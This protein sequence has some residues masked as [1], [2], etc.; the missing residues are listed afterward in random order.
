MLQRRQSLYLFLV[1]ILSIV[2]F[3]GPLASVSSGDAVYFLKHSGVTDLSGERLEMSTWPL[4]VM[5]SISTLLS[6]LAIFSYLK[7]P[8]QMRMTL[9]LMF[10]NLGIVGIVAYYVA[11]IMHNY[12]G[13]Q[14]LFE[15]R[16]VIPPVMLVLLIMAFRGIRK[17]ELMVRAADRIR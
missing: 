15:W 5:I 8:R 1:F 2:L 3:T 10:F 7:R 14:F 9:F 17:D 6:L 11:Y 12:H 4:T 16:I 13:E